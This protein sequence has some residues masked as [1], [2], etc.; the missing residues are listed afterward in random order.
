M[1]IEDA[2]WLDT[3]KRLAVGT[4]TRIKH[5]FES[6]NNL[7]IF[8]NAD[9]WSCW[10]FACNEGSRVRKSSPVLVEEPAPTK[11]SLIPLPDDCVALE[12]ASE[13]LQLQAHRYLLKRGISPD[14]HINGVNVLV[15]AKTQRLCIEMN[16]GAYVGRGMGGQKIK[17]I[18][19]SSKPYTKY[20]HHP[21]WQ[22]VSVAGKKVVLTEDY[23]SAL[24]VQSACP[25]VIAISAQGSG[26]GQELV[27]KVL[28]AEQV[29]VMLDGDEAGYKG[30]AKMVSRLKGL[31]KTTGIN[32][33]EGKDPKNL[34]IKDIRRLVYDND[35]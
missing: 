19:Y 10:C 31:V 4:K 28:N 9:S 21:K 30:T 14:L 32:T 26:I 1:T 24:K 29:Y 17:A 23:L 11:G 25:E 3:A 20:A 33:P 6:R 13:A 18:T 22:G 16:G 15:S 34:N 5:G 8:N 35:V 27:A 12:E 7:L 2:E